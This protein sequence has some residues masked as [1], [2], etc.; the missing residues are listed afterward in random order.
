VT[1]EE[2]EQGFVDAGWEL[3]GGFSGYLIIGEDEHLSIIAH[4]WMWGS[5]DPV[6][7]LSDGG[8]EL[9]CWVQEIPTPQQAAELLEEYGGPPEE[10]WGDPYDESTGRNGEEGRNG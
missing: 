6:F 7:E 9:T 3:D 4:R 1:R 10:E 2:I 5:D 8:R